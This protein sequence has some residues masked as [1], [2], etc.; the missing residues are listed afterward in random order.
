MIILYVFIVVLLILSGTG[1][2]VYIAIRS[3]GRQNREY[4]EYAKI[5][6]FQFDKG[7]VKVG[8]YRDYSKNT[9]NLGLKIPN[10]GTY[11]DKYANYLSYPFGRGIEKQV[12]YII[13]GKYKSNSFKAFNYQFTGSMIDGGGKGGVFKIIM[14]EGVKKPS[15]TPNN[16]FYES[17][18]LCYYDS[19]NLDVN[20]IKSVLDEL[21]NLIN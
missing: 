16:T 10:K 13:K 12:S 19:G 17:D 11:I 18:T 2:I 5:N 9:I 3:A 1:L 20:E 7:M 15:L 6:N 21:I 14:L 4:E 8:N